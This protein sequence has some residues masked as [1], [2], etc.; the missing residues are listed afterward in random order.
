MIWDMT[1][2]ILVNTYG[3]LWGR[4]CLHSGGGNVLN[5]LGKFVGSF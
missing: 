5:V 4:F 1:P 3:R 2:Y